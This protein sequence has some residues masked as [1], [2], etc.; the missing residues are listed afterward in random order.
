MPEQSENFPPGDDPLDPHVTPDSPSDLQS[1]IEFVHQKF[2]VTR[3]TSGP[4]PPPAMLREYEDISPGLAERLANMAEDEAKHRRAVENKLIGIY[5]RDQ[6][7]S[8]Q[9]E[10]RGQLYGLLI[11]VGAIVGAVILRLHG[12]TAASLGLGTGGLTPG[13]RVGYR[14]YPWQ[15]APAKGA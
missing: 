2:E 3:E 11:G 13:Y 1:A 14:L 10:A 6:I 8:R 4:I 12:Q 5:S 9:I 7:A 15:N